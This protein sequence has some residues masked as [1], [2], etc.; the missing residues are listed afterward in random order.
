MARVA[1]PDTDTRLEQRLLRHLECA[2]EVRE[3]AHLAPAVVHRLTE[4]F[5]H[6]ESRIRTFLDTPDS[7]LAGSSPADIARVHGFDALDSLVDQVE[8]ATRI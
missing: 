4:V 7:T 6:D 8:Y 5:G 3:S 1:R 2:T